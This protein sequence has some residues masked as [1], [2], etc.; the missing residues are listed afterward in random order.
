MTPA[1]VD[2]GGGGGGQERGGKSTVNEK[3]SKF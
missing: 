1:L 2:G 3:T